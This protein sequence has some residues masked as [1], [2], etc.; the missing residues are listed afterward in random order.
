MSY[1]RTAE[2]RINIAQFSRGKH[3]T[4]SS[5]AQLEGLVSEIQID[6]R[7]RVVEDNRSIKMEKTVVCTLRRKIEAQKLKLESKICFLLQAKVPKTEISISKAV[8]EL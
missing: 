3:R 2:Y 7:V 1:S 5:I 4:L 8:T 6:Y